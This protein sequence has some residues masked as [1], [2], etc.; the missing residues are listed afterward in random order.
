MWT[1][2]GEGERVRGYA[3]YQLTYS[4]PA[5]SEDDK[6]CSSMRRLVVQLEV[7][8]DEELYDDKDV[9]T[10]SK[11]SI[12]NSEASLTNESAGVCVTVLCQ[13]MKELGRHGYGH[14][15]RCQGHK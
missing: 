4:P 8:D 1:V 11:E 3:Q 9:E 2:R 6:E 5:A 13:D 12:I 10:N 15:Q 14:V 7:E